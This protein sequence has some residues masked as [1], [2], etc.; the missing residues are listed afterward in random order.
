[1]RNLFDGHPDLFSVPFESHFFQSI[2]Y[3]VSYYFRRTSPENLTYA[4][5]KDGLFGWIEKSN[6]TERTFADGFTKGLFNMNEVRDMLFGEETTD[7]RE[8]S[9]LYIK[10]I[11][12]GLTGKDIP[13]QTEFVEK[14]VENVEFAQDVL[15]IYPGARFV[16]ILRN[17]YSNLVAIRNY[18]AIKQMGSRKR[19]PRLRNA[20]FAMH[21]SYHNLYQNKRLID[22]Y[23]VVRYEDVLSTPEQT[24][25]KVATFLGLDYDPILI[26]P[27]MLGKPWDGNS[28]TGNRF[29]QVSPANID[30]WKT[31]ISPLETWLVNRLFP[32]VLRDFGFDGIESGSLPLRP[33]K[34]EGLKNYAYNRLMTNFLPS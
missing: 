22:N 17:P 3:W 1:M 34:G 4:Q 12:R 2:R 28:T 26:S 32:F 18:S 21:S 6:A 13:E 30:R 20:V 16:H 9:D 27:T 14:S 25:R 10:S 15:K 24:M 7:L 19:Y 8:L 11:Y 29:T 31:E 33:S 5:M 23:L